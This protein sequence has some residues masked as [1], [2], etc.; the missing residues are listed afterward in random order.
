MQQLDECN[1]ISNDTLKEIAH[2]S[3]L[4]SNSSYDE[5]RRIRD[6]FGE[7][8]PI[9]KLVKLNKNDSPYLFIDNALIK[10]TDTADSKRKAKRKGATSGNKSPG[11]TKVPRR[12]D[13]K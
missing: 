6:I 2:K 7:L 3:E 12:D 11:Q 4:V 10:R 13:S 8:I 9:S 5:V 1:F